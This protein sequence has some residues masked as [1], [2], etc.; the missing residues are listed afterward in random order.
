MQ[1]YMSRKTK[2]EILATAIRK[3]ILNLSY[4]A[5]IGHLGSAFSVVDILTVLYFQVMKVDPQHPLLLQR[6]RFILS[7]GHAGA[8]LFTVLKEKGYFSQ[9]I[10]AS[11]CQNGSLL[12]VHP[13][14]NNL[15]GIEAGTG[16]LGHGLPVVAGIAYAAK[17]TGQKYHSYVLISDAECNEGTIWE[18]ALFAGHQQL[19]NLTVII[20]YNGTQALGQVKDILDLEPLAD[21][22]QAFGWHV[23]TVDGHNFSQ[24]KSAFGLKTKIPKVII[25]KTTMGKGV[26]F[27]END[28]RLH[29]YDPKLEHLTLALK[30]LI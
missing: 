25:A 7:K 18:A 9:Q 20:D 11:Y 14:Y 15:P 1:T 13:E 16:S 10:L 26:S 19:D 28:F 2:L 22:W 23:Q 30:E 24:L 12:L 4:A 27:M 5:H 29:Y 17:K 6:D 21:K 3:Q 8:A